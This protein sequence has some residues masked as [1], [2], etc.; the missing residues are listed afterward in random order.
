MYSATDRLFWLGLRLGLRLWEPETSAQEC[1]RRA[2]L[3][4]GGVI[5]GS[6]RG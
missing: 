6:F 2:L 3:F 5:L 4:T 1:E